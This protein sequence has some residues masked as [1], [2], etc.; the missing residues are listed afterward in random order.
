MNE[1]GCF[2]KTVRIMRG[3]SKKEVCDKV[4]I[5]RQYLT[6]IED[7]KEYFSINRNMSQ[8]LQEALNISLVND[9][10]LN[11]QFLHLYDLFISHAIMANDT[12]AYKA[13]NEIMSLRELVSASTLLPT[14]LLVELV[15][16]TMYKKNENEFRRIHDIILK[17]LPHFNLHQKQIYYLF[18]GVYL[19]D[20]AEYKSA[21]EVLLTSLELRTSEEIKAYTH[22]Q[23]G[24]AYMQS[25]QNLE[26]I[27]I[28]GLSKATFMNKYNYTRSLQ[29]MNVFT[30]IYIKLREYNIAIK[31]VSHVETI[32]I[33]SGHQDILNENV[34]NLILIHFFL[35]QYEEALTLCERQVLSGHETPVLIFLALFCSWKL[36]KEISFIKHYKIETDINLYDGLSIILKKMIKKPQR[37][38]SYLLKSLERLNKSKRID[39][40]IYRLYYREL[41]TYYKGRENYQLALYYHEQYYIF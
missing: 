15:H 22:Y 12:I 28:L 10:T 20:S 40:L 32:A 11:D 8:R 7:T 5:S 34:E 26:A 13:Y 9:I 41:C 19:N 29:C 23:L 37:V 1:I 38:E 18:F 17:I 4:K 14:F 39:H 6:K 16:I 2:F 36:S 3:I 24:V 25:N 31:F 30:K 35:E 21:I 33:N 27:N